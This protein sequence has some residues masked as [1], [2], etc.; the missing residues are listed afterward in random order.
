MGSNCK[1]TAHLRS[2]L[3]QKCKFYEILQDLAEVEKEKPTKQPLDLNEVL[4]ILEP[5]IVM[6]KSDSQE[7]LAKFGRLMERTSEAE[8]SKINEGDI[9]GVEEI[10]IFGDFGE[11]DEID[12]QVEVLRY[13]KRRYRES[14]HR[15]KDQLKE[16]RIFLKDVSLLQHT[17]LTH[18][19]PASSCLPPPALSLLT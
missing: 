13:L 2:F 17:L 4:K 12:R 8:E 5:I 9:F 10:G 1:Y 11:L 7:L 19:L 14:K 15:P 16:S 18:T 6:K 3:T